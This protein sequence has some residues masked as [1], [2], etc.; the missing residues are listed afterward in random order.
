[1]YDRCGSRRAPSPRASRAAPPRD[2]PAFVVVLLY[3]LLVASVAWSFAFAW[4]TP[5]QVLGLFAYVACVD[6][7]LLGVTLATA[8]WWCANNYLHVEAQAHAIEVQ[9]WAAP[10][11]RREQARRRR[12]RRRQARACRRRAR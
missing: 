6:F 9:P 1:M 2:D 8:G 5:L 12:R 10:A 11:E 4:R 3:L 7:L